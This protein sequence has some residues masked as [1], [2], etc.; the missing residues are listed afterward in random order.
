[1]SNELFV[2]VCIMHEIIDTYF[3]LRVEDEGNPAILVGPSSILFIL[4]RLA[5]IP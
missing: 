4:H 1:M 3:T 5:N 2:N